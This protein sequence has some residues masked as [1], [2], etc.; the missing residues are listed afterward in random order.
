MSKQL[1]PIQQELVSIRVPRMARIWDI[2][3][4]DGTVLRFASHPTVISFGGNDYSPLDG[5]DHSAT[6]E[7]TD[8]DESNSEIGG[9]LSD[10]RITDAD[11]KAGRY[12]DALLIERIVDYLVPNRGGE[13]YKRHWW[14]G[15]IA[16]DG[17]RWKAEINGLASWMSESV[18]MVANRSCRFTLGDSKCQ[19]DLS[20]GG[21]E[22]SGTITAI[23]VQRRTFQTDVSAAIAANVTGVNDEWYQFGLLTITT[24]ANADLVG[25][26]FEV[27]SFTETNGI[28][29]LRT[30]TPLDLTVNDEFTITPG[31]NKS[32]AA[33]K[34]KYVNYDNFGGDPFI[35]G[36]DKAGETPSASD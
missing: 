34:T 23:D 29:T 17:E 20:G 10:S 19:K 26:E 28:I 22:Q 36:G 24:A 11:M 25:L 3:R 6:Q 8:L 4:Q 12:E 27:R 1:T 7:M 35:P 2:H 21:Y 31:C 18:G 9:I 30:R 14:L 16:W 32:A 33:C 13:L 5:F 15:D